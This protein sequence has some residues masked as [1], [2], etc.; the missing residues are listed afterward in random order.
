MPTQIG[1]RSNQPGSNLEFVDEDSPLPVQLIPLNYGSMVVVSYGFNRPA[2]G[3]AYAA[4]DAVSN[5]TSAPSVVTFTG[6]ARTPGGSGYI[7]KLRIITDQKANVARYRLHLFTSP[8]IAINDNAVQT[9]LWND[10]ANRIGALSITA[11]ATEDTS[12]TA[13]EQTD[14]VDRL[15]FLCSGSGMN[16]YGLLET[17]DIFTPA[18]AQGF[19]I[20][21]VIDQN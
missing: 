4:G 3:T 16:L 5:S 11:L 1:W 13:A 10:R 15:P 17:L 19:Y 6:A 9:I 14:I 8:P 20:E 7:T 18:S 2:D 12:S 21:L